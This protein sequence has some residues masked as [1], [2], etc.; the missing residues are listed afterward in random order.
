MSQQCPL[1]EQIFLHLS[2]K[3]DYRIYFLHGQLLLGELE[4]SLGDEAVLVPVHGL[5][6]R[7]AVHVQVQEVSRLHRYRNT[8]IQS[9]TLFG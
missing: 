4:F 3:K 7:L 1:N 9:N 6:G 5:E 8:V 2:N